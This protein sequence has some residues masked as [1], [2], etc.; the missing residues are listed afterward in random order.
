VCFTRFVSL[1]CSFVLVAVASDGFYTLTGYSPQETLGRNCRFLQ[2]KDTDPRAIRF[3]RY[4]LN[5]GLDCSI[6]VRNYKK[7]GEAFWN[8]LFMIPL[9]SPDGRVIN[10]LGVQRDLPEDDP[11]LPERLAKQEQVLGAF[12]LATA[13]ASAAAAAAA[14][15][16]GQQAVKQSGAGS[17]HSSG[18]SGGNSSSAAFVAAP[19]SREATTAASAKPASGGGAAKGAG[20]HIF[21]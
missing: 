3:M 16:A 13:S 15:S 7:N 6:I 8:D 5:S 14:A 11:M 21:Y 19:S 10:F 1:C 9:R 18:S 12:E 4:R 17:S 2:G 20:A